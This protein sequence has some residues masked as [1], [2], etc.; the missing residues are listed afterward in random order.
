MMQTLT[1]EQIRSFEEIEEEEYVVL[2][3]ISDEECEEL[4]EKHLRVTAVSSGGLY[5]NCSVSGGSCSGC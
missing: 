2:D 3:E 1:E 5:P 4:V